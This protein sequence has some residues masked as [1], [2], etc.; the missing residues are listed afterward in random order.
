MSIQEVIDFL[1]QRAQEIEKLEFT[2]AS[3]EEIIDFGL[4][5]KN[6]LRVLKL[7]PGSDF[8]QSVDLFQ[9]LLEKEFEGDDEKF[10]NDS[11]E[12]LLMDTS[13]LVSRL[14]KMVK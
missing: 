5:T 6:K 3:V 2:R 9:H 1:I 14:E 7:S 10:F 4:D 13:L 11:R 12:D 8:M